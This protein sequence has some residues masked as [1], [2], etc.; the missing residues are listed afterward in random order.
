M[1][2]L[3][4]IVLLTVRMGD[5]VCCAVKVCVWMVCSESVLWSGSVRMV[6]VCV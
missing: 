1:C 3:L 5:Q 4:C 2:L 6:G